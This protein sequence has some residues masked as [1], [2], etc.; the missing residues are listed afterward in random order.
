MVLTPPPFDL[1][2]KLMVPLGVGAGPN[3]LKSVKPA[4]STRSL[5]K[6]R[7][8]PVLKA[9]LL[10]SAKVNAP[11][12]AEAPLTVRFSAATLAKP[13]ILKAPAKLPVVLSVV[14]NEPRAVAAFSKPKRM[15]NVSAC[16]LCPQWLKEDVFY[17][18][19]H[20]K[21]RINYFLRIIHTF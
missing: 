6:S 9:R 19:C 15:L 12:P 13:K 3:T 14:V 8:E 4:C 21:P 5:V 1:S 11:L 17:S 20:N 18:Y 16:A 7:A 2:V 10:K